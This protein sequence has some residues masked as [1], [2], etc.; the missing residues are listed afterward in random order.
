[1]W[2][3]AVFLD[4]LATALLNSQQ[5]STKQDLP[6]PTLSELVQAVSS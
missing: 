6:C 5:V 4:D 1:M 2:W 3:N